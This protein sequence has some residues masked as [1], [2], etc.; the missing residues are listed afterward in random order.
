M[1]SI[2]VLSTQFGFMRLNIMTHDFRT[3]DVVPN[4]IFISN[5]KLIAYSIQIFYT[6]LTLVKVNKLLFIKN[7]HLHVKSQTPNDMLNN[8]VNLL[9]N[10]IE[11]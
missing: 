3:F 1:K 7:V 2:F 10:M 11:V 4:T 9:I 8:L 5:V 6:C